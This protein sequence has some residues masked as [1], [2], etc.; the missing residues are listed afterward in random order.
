MAKKKTPQRSRSLMFVQQTKHLLSRF[1][2][3]EELETHLHKHFGDAEWAYISHDKDRHEDQS[4]IEHHLHISFYFDNPR[5]P[6]AI[7]KLM[8]EPKED[9]GKSIE[10]FTGIYA[11]NNVFAYLIHATAE[12]MNDK[13]KHKYDAEDVTANF[14]YSNY[15]EN[16]KT[17]ADEAKL[18]LDEIKPKVING[19]L[20]LKDFFRD[21]ELG[22]AQVMAGFY[23]DNKTKINNYIESRY[24]IQ[25]ASEG[26]TDLEIIYIQGAAG[27]G[28]TVIAKEYAKRK[29]GDY[30]ITGSSNDAVQDYMGESVAIFD[31]ARPT[32]FGTSDWLK[33]LDPYNN[34]STVASRYYNK[35]LAVKCIIVTTTTDFN[36][37]FVYAQD[38]GSVDD[39]VSQ[40]MRRFQL[41][42][43]VEPKEDDIGNN[44]AVG[45]LFRIERLAEPQIRKVANK[46]ITYEHVLKKEDG[47]VIKVEIPKTDTT[48]VV[49]DV[50]RFFNNA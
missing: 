10:M 34:K 18:S 22:T 35:Y 12:A 6:T 36:D 48:A 8:G 40:F 17:I 7:A 14:N 50:M 33:M 43:K 31:D 19:D 24:T 41:V 32:D 1:K 23:S 42:V 45:Q 39:P 9:N 11:K 3:K 16:V 20:I 13:D 2:D 21:G 27:S 29:Y 47:K 30:F 28:K 38:K 26:G 25:L 37:F 4:F 44:Y 49:N 46:E 15:I 5:T